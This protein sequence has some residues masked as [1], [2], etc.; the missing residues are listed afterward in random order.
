[1]SKKKGFVPP[2]DS[3]IL[4]VEDKK[5]LLS[6]VFPKMR[7]LERIPAGAIIMHVSDEDMREKLPYSEK[8]WIFKVMKWGRSCNDKMYVLFEKD[9]KKL[10]K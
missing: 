6:H 10:R 9:F 3:E 4:C 5:G 7:K 2:T 1:M 8:S